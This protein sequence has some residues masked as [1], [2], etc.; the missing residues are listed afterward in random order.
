MRN[1]YAEVTSNKQLRTETVQ[2][3]RILPAAVTTF[4]LAGCGAGE[5]DACA[6]NQATRPAEVVTQ[7]EV[8]EVSE[9]TSNVDVQV[10]STLDERVRLTVRFDDTL[11]LDIYLPDTPRRCPNQPVY[12]Y[13]YRLP[14]GQAIVTATTDRGQREATTLTAGGGKRW[15]AVQIQDGFPLELDTVGTLREA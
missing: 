5:S 1:R 15:V 14:A 10:I 9:S 4:L 13:A 6:V 7:P 8:A 11:A 12:Q 3:K 2:V